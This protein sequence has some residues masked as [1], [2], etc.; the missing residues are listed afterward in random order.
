MKEHQQSLKNIDTDTCNAIIA[1][2]G[3]EKQLKRCEKRG[4]VDMC[5]ALEELYQDGVKVGR[6]AGM[7]VGR[8]AGIRGAVELCQ[9]FGMSKEMA[10]EK[11]KEKYSLKEETALK[12][13]D[14][15][16]Q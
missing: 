9:E 2:L 3:A 4:G 11:I 8:E 6:E 12:Y 16:W 1:L 14:E 7:L 13:I 5:Q 10:L 15:Y